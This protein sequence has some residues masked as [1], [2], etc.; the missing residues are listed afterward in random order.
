[1]TNRNIV[2]KAIL[3]CGI[4]D[5]CILDG[6]DYYLEEIIDEMI[7]NGK[8]PTLNAIVGEVFRK[9]VEEL[10]LLI[11]DRLCAPGKDD[12]AEVLETLRTL[13][14][15]RDISWRCNWRDTSIRFCENER[16][17]RSYLPEEICQVESNMGVSF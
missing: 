11:S 1:M 15:E 16:I 9:G 14:P 7:S 4:S 10:A 8:T 3:D 13:N 5:L 17:Y 12:S 2:L 6:I